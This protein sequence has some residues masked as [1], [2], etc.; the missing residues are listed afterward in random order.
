MIRLG[1]RK[2]F[3]FERLLILIRLYI[4][5]LRQLR[6]SNLASKIY[7]FLFGLSI[8]WFVCFIF[9]SSIQRSLRKSC[10]AIRRG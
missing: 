1:K 5:D 10:C 7:L 9:S 4:F 8:S 2:S 6:F 3:Q